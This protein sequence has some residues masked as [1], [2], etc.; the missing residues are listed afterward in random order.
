MSK[1]V[2]NVLTADIK[3]RL[4]GVGDCVVG[5]MIGLNSEATVSLRRKMR[6][7]NITVLVIKNSLA[8]RATEGT[9]L[10]P[11]FEG[12][13]GT[14]AVLFGGEDFISLIKEVTALD[15][16]DKFEAFKARGGVMDGERLTAEKVKEISSWPN[17]REQLSL[18]VGQILGPGSKLSSQLIGPA[19]KLVSQI[20]KAGEKNG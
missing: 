16:D 1:I 18:L 11:A 13:R 9:S 14:S 6:A 8:R 15:K 2:K 3:R 20:D 5:N 4:A 17:R 10:G 7:K 19:G 12:L